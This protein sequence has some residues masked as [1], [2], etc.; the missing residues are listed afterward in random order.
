[1]AERASP[2]SILV[3]WNPPDPLGGTTG[4]RIDYTRDGDS[5]DIV[6]V[7][8][9]FTNEILLTDLLNGA[10]YSISIVATSSYL[11]S[12]IVVVTDVHLGMSPVSKYALCSMCDTV[13][14]QP[15]VTLGTIT[16]TSIFL[17]WSVPSGSIITNYTIAWERDVTVGCPNEDED[18]IT[19][20]GDS[21]SYDIMGLEEDSR[22]TIVLA[23]SNAA[24]SSTDSDTVMTEEAGE[25]RNLYFSVLSPLFG[26]V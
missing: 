20:I 5:G 6:T 2:T 11:P 3:S 1:M 18:S 12:E 7:N 4:Y 22:Y 23:I 17:S 15:S 24:G 16:S 26:A 21:T 14:G 25:D 19:I 8:G 10:T 9:G 13:P